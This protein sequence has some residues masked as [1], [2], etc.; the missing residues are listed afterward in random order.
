ME[1]DD[2]SGSGGGWWLTTVYLLSLPTADGGTRGGDRHTG[3]LDR[4][5]CAVAAAG[6]RWGWW[7]SISCRSGGGGDVVW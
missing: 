2:V 3:L 5:V 6:G 1:R 4:F 7:L